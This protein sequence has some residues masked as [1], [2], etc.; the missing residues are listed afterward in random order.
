MRLLFVVGLIA[1]TQA[2]AVPAQIAPE[3]PRIIV[4]GYG[5][6]KTMPDVAT[7]SYTLRGEGATSDEAVRGMVAMGDRIEAALRGIDGAADPRTGNVRVSP[8]KGSN[9]KT[10]DYDSGDQLSKGVCAITG[11]IATQNVTV[12][13]A[14]VKDAGTMVGIVGRGGAYNARVENF[15]I[16]DPRS[17]KRQAIAAALTEAQAKAAAIASGSQTRLGPILSISTT[18]RDSGEDI[19]ITGSRLPQAN[20]NSGTPV[21]VKLRPEPITTSANVTVTY[22][23]Q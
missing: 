1:I 11:Y 15:D 2:A 3:R 14:S 23:I 21:T 10:E 22:A 5:E 12:R 4:D 19:V 17:A 8:A 18:G 6:V 9:C 13:T 7:I 20:M 16:Q